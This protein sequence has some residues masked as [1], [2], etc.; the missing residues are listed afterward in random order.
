VASTDSVAGFPLGRRL[1]DFG[2]RQALKLR[3][4]MTRRD[5][6]KELAAG[7]DP[8]SGPALALRATQLLRPRY[9][10]ALARAVERLVKNADRDPRLSS[11]AP[12]ARDQVAEARDT[13]LSIAQVLRESPSVQPRGVAMLWILLS[14]G[15][16]PVY[17]PTAR[18]VLELQAQL[19]LACLVGQ[20]WNSPERVAAPSRGP[21][22][23]SDGD[24]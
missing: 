24:R 23:G 5:L 2:R 3:V 15:N 17:L 1:V 10:R 20:S 11:A 7:V 6:S 16:S 13:L 21:V 12:L 19:A 22:G 14:D 4:L 9:R 8:S 18:G